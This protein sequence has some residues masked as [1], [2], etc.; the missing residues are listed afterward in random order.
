MKRSEYVQKA[1]EI[2]KNKTN[3]EKFLDIMAYTQKYSL[4]NQIEIYD[5]AES[6]IMALASA[7]F[8]KN[9]MHLELKDDEVN[10]YI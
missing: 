8:W 6:D 9:N 4:Y 5:Q 7:D 1:I 10:N 2:F 3:L